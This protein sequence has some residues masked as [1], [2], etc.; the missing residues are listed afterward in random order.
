MKPKFYI[1]DQV[2]GVL[3]DSPES[4]HL[5]VAPPVH[6]QQPL[7]VLLYCGEEA[8]LPDHHHHD[9]CHVHQDKALQMY[10]LKYLDMNISLYESD[11]FY[12]IVEAGDGKY[13]KRELCTEK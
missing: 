13:W 12:K 11:R 5:C 10:L 3:H 7:L 1:L 9:H 4:L 8:E 2:P 6:H